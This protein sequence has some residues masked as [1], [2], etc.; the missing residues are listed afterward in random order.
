MTLFINSPEYLRYPTSDSVH[1][2]LMITVTPRT[3]QW[4]KN[5]FSLSPNIHLVITNVP[6]DS[7]DG[8]CHRETIYLQ[9]RFVLW[10]Q[11]VFFDLDVLELLYSTDCKFI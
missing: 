1:S 2:C 8:I 10:T 6:E 9:A 7:G 4:S 5:H 11:A 3:G